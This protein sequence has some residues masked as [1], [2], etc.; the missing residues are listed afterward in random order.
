MIF[1]Q[2]ILQCFLVVV[3]NPVQFS[4]PLELNILLV[5]S[6]FFFNVPVLEKFKHV[7][8]HGVHVILEPGY[9]LAELLDLCDQELHGVYNVF[10]L[11]VKGD[12][13]DDVAHLDLEQPGQLFHFDILD[14]VDLLSQ[15]EHD[16][17]SVEAPDHT[18]DESVQNPDFNVDFEQT[19]TVADF[20]HGFVFLGVQN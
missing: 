12:V 13:R 17:Q 9:K 8:L 6:R 1:Y 4:V 14:S 20:T 19:Q 3:E 10:R 2:A 11:G 7:L 15:P 5:H 18:F 16:H